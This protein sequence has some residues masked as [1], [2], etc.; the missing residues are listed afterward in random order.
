MRS[1]L[2]LPLS[3]R[4]WSASLSTLQQ[5]DTRPSPSTPTA[6]GPPPPASSYAAAAARPAAPHTPAPRPAAREL[7][8]RESERELVVIRT[9]PLPADDAL[10]ALAPPRL[11][12]YIRNKVSFALDPR[13]VITAERLEKG[14]VRVVLRDSSSAALFRRLVPS[15]F[16]PAETSTPV[17]RCVVF[18]RNVPVSM[19]VEAVSTRVEEV[20]E[21][22]VVK[23]VKGLPVREGW[24]G[25]A[26]GIVRAAEQRERRERREAYLQRHAPPPPPRPK[27]PPP[28][29]ADLPAPPALRQHSTPARAGALPAASP[30]VGALR[31]A[32]PHLPPRPPTPLA[33]EYAPMPDLTLAPT[34]EASSATAAA[35]AADESGSVSDIT[36][37]VIHEEEDA[38]ANILGGLDLSPLPAL[39]PL[40]SD[41]PATP[42]SR[43]IA[44]DTPSPDCVF[45]EHSHDRAAYRQHV[46]ES[47]ARR[48]Q[49][50]AAAA[51]LPA[52]SVSFETEDDGNEDWREK[53]LN[54]L[55]RAD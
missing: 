14:D 44:S 43:S 33:T 40:H 37:T 39:P 27:T 24:R 23:A 36:D 4:L 50:A 21:K 13:A 10:R 45:L 25:R 34:A 22:G 35:A 55:L 48:A 38:P 47:E 20:T 3:L 51:P 8:R 53:S 26:G 28:P 1:P 52:D 18:L 54:E 11:P 6:D 2:L 49:R 41:A 32:P 17:E 19:P 42:R 29:P 15:A 12:S 31:D 30:G 5:T 16:P 9:S 7:T 46:D